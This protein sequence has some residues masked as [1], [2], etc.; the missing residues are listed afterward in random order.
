[1]KRM[2]ARIGSRAR[3]M[4]RSLLLAGVAATVA[5]PLSGQFRITPT[6]GYSF[7]G[8]ITSSNTTYSLDDAFSWGGVLGFDVARQGTFELVFD[9]SS[10]DVTERDRGTN[11]RSRLGPVDVWSLQGGG[12]YEFGGSRNVSP[13]LAGGLG[14]SVYNPGDFEGFGQLGTET[15]FG[16]N[17][18]LGA[19]VARWI[20]VGSRL[21]MTLLN[22]GGGFWCGPG[23]CAIGGGGEVLARWELYGGINIGGRR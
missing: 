20:R 8:S 9:W 7:G 2:G 4:S 18:G 10:T 22:A 19:D 13:F 3:V 17:V 11:V 16:F 1:M 15:R 14:V 6:A 23:G 21:W 5:M 12:L